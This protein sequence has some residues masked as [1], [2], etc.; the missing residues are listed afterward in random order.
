M[1]T[2]GPF[3]L[4]CLGPLVFLPPLPGMGNDRV[5]GGALTPAAIL[6][7]RR[8]GHRQHHEHPSGLPSR[9]GSNRGQA[10]LTTLCVP[11]RVPAV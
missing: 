3:A 9:S 10:Q 7:S 1:D 11:S 5:L 6:L 8:S 2:R 4:L